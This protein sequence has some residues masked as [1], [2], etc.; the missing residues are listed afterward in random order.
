[1]H[2]DDKPLAHGEAI[3]PYTVTRVLGSG[4][5]GVVY[6][7]LKRPL[8]KRVA[9][10]V[11]RRMHAAD[12]DLTSRFLREAQAAASLKHPHIVEVDDVG[13]EDGI[14]FFAMEFLEGQNLADRIDQG[15]PMST[16]RA[17]DLMLPVCSA[18]AAVHTRGIIHRDLKPDNILLWQPIPGQM[19]PK[20]L[21]F[22]IAK[23]QP[24]L[25]EGSL[26]ATGTR[27]GTPRYM[28][29]EQWSSSKHTTAQSDQWALAVIVYECLTATTP[30][31][32][33]EMTTLVLKMAT[34]PPRPLRSLVPDAPEALERVLAQALSRDPA[35]RYP[36]VREFARALLP[37]ASAGT[38]ARWAAEFDPFPHNG[39]GDTMRQ[40]SFDALPRATP[41]SHTLQHA[42]TEIP[43]P[44]AATQPPRSRAL[45]VVATAAVL[46]AAVV[47][48]VAFL[49]RDPTHAVSPTVVVA[50]TPLRAAA[51]AP[52]PAPAA[53][54]APAP[55]PP[56]PPAP[57]VA[58]PTHA[59]AEPT[60]APETD[61]VPGEAPVRRHGRR[62][63]RHG[64][65]SQAPS[66]A[67]SSEMP[68]L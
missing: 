63:R 26:T 29:P 2:N 42:A 65:E 34:E 32:A 25:L 54:A 18:V 1:M 36:T 56:A 47:G 27:F 30:Y 3:G 64:H 46:S 40:G 51:V 41:A 31:D 8:D 38:Q 21:D 19:H 7:A 33:E 23:M 22:G 52:A 17:L 20:L 55:T 68:N 35:A 6:E 13:A 53:P 43:R 48:G 15:G 5:F 49:L 58:E 14:P 9:L 67:A 24:Q 59:L 50:P 12:P 62:H 4:A 39:R 16:E 11:L 44:R 45:G 37:F 61:A 66:A 10:K 28:P 60:M 57:S